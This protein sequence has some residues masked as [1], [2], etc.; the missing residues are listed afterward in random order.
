MVSS[1]A[2]AP[3][4]CCFSLPGAQPPAHRPWLAQ[5]WPK[6]PPHMGLHD[7]EWPEVWIDG[8]VA[9]PSTIRAFPVSRPNPVPH[10][11]NGLC[12]GGLMARVPDK[13][14]HGGPTWA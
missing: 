14:G 13:E 10:S 2:G 5:T 3:S 11:T 1:R 8:Q 9:P 12:R 7:A 4:S 6:C